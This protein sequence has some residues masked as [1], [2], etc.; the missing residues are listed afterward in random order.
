MQQLIS[1]ESIIIGNRLFERNQAVIDS[2]VESIK[3]VGLKSA[4]SVRPAQTQGQYLL[5]SGYHRLNA[6]IE[7]A[8]TDDTYNSIAAI[9]ETL[10]DVQAQLAEIDENLI[11]NQ[12]TDYA[13][14]SVIYAKR[15]ELYDTLHPELAGQQT[16]S[17][18]KGSVPPTGR[19]G[20]VEKIETF[21]ESTARLSKK[22]ARSVQKA[23]QVGKCLAANP[24]LLK[25]TQEQNIQARVLENTVAL[26]NSSA[27]EDQPYI[28]KLKKHI[29]LGSDI[30]QFIATYQSAKKK[31]QAKEKADVGGNT[32][33][34]AEPLV[35]PVVIDKQSLGDSIDPCSIVTV[36]LKDI[37]VGN[38]E[39]A[40]KILADY[41]LQLIDET[42]KLGFD[43]NLITKQLNSSICAETY[44]KTI[45]KP[46]E[47]KKEHK[48]KPQEDV[49]QESLPQTNATS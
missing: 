47:V 1:I 40:K 17:L 9:V 42:V 7:L 14:L 6:Y 5:V 32:L 4:I 25:L 12:V 3:D 49:Q 20:K 8:K 46:K 26:L 15:K 29:G 18:R 34:E 39:S 11:R 23:V 27:E 16:A 33:Q 37:P 28:S 48:S 24:E 41:V 22:S 45:S 21:V 35:T 10:S 13:N 30:K 19:D 44:V 31:K 43:K 38:S 2:L 36:L